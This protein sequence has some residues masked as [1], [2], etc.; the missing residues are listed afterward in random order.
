MSLIKKAKRP[1]AKSETVPTPKRSLSVALGVARMSRKK[2]KIHKMAEMLPKESD[3]SGVPSS[4]SLAQAVRASK[5]PKDSEADLDANNEEI[6]DNSYDDMNKLAFEEDLYSADEQVEDQP[7]D[8]N[9]D[10]VELDSDK[11]DMISA[12]RRKMR[13]RGK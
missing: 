1:S 11:H 3:S 13:L 9:E 8:S 4:M 12:I 2:D 7:A 6:L 5:K 10:D